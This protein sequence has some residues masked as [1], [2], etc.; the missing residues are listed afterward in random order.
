MTATTPAQ[1]ADIIRLHYVEHWPVGTIATQLGLHPD[2]VKRVLGLGEP[3]PE[4]PRRP[5][6]VE[7][8]H[9]FIVEQLTRYPRLR[10]TRIYDMVRDR[11]YAGAVTTVRR[12][13]ADVR[14][15]PRREVYLRTEPLIGEQAQA[16]WAYV[17]KLAV[18][19][20]VRALWLFV[21]VLAYSRAIWAEFVID[22]SVHSLCRSLVRGA[23][24]FA[25][26]TRQWLFDNPKIVVLERHGDAVRFHPVLLELCAKMRAQP[27]LCAVRRPQHKGKVER[28][29]RYLRD[30]FLA[31]RTI[32]GVD[33]GNAQ[34]GRFIDTV[35]HARPHPVLAQRTVGDVFAEERGRLLALPAPLP[36]TDRLE[37]VNLDRQAFVQLDTNRYSVPTAVAERQHVVTLVS[38]DRTVR[39]LDGATVVAEHPRSWGRRQVIEDP[40]HRTELVAQRRA[41]RNLKGRD[42]LHAVAPRFGEL[43]A[44]WTATGPS[45]GLRVTRAI[46][47]LELY[48]DEVFAAAVADLAERGLADLGALAVACETQRKRHDRPMPVLPDLSIHADD[49]HVVIPH[50]LERYDAP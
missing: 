44:R 18:P 10:A 47:L 2:V 41:A 28:A 6:I 20:G 35:A 13:V 32:V 8:Y 11:G 30:R 48:G 25:G 19:G 24:A 26:T 34:L 17:G 29:I 33:E 49:D 46:K 27:R 12:Y 21:M 45:L 4:A 23:R 38:D 16:D 42:R 37:L 3:R 50:D 9:D 15:P 14:P 36:S 40:A 43:L 7:P 1:D 31:G 22:L 39:V 5:R